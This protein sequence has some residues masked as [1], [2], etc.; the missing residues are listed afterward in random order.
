MEIELTDVGKRWVQEHYTQ[1]IVW[2]YDPD[3]TFN[4]HTMAAERARVC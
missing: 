3:K 2:E 4:L 1:G